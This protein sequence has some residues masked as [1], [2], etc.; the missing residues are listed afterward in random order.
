[1][2][3]EQKESGNRGLLGRHL[4]LETETCFFI[5]ANALDAI[6]TRMLLNFPQFRE[7]NVIADTILDR[8]GMPGMIAFKF[9]IVAA[10]VIIA[11]IIAPR[12]LHVARYLL[13]GGTVFVFAVVIYSCYLWVA[14]SGFIFEPPPNPRIENAGM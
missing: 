11:Q 9:T 14:Y 7:S 13:I 5:L 2:N 8:F 4:P 6:M 3:A 10:V 1:M 12:K